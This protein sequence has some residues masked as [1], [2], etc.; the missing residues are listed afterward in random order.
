MP[1]VPSLSFHPAVHAALDEGRPVVA[2]ESTVISYGLPW[3][4]NLE[5]ARA[6]MEEPVRAAP[7][8]PP[9]CCW[10]GHVRRSIE[11]P[12]EST[13][14]NDTGVLAASMHNDITSRLGMSLLRHPHSS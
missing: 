6:T 5:L 1:P 2:L 10:A 9:W 4:E 3:P 11:S 12:G 14:D 8:R 7:S 13:D